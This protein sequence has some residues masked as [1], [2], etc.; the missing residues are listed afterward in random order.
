[1]INISKYNSE[2]FFLFAFVIKCRFYKLHERKVEPISM[3][4]PR[5]V[6]HALTLDTLFAAFRME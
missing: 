4:A 5:K 6:S 2:A 3:I 1:M